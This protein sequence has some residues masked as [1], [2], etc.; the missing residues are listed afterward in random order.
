MMSKLKNLKKAKKKLTSWLNKNFKMYE[1]VIIGAGIA[2]CT[3]AIYAAR[4]KMNF[5]FIS[6]I[7][8][9]Q[10]FEA[11][12]VLNYPGIVKT[13]GIDFSNVLKRQLEF[14]NV[15]LTEGLEVKSIEKIKNGFKILTNKEEFTAK[16]VIIATGSH[17][18]RLNVK[19]EAEFLHKGLTYCAVCDGPFFSGMDIAIIGGGSSAL[20]AV[21]FTKNI[22]KKI[23][24]I[25][26]NK[27]FEAHEYLIEKTKALD[28]VEIISEADTIEVFGDK[29]VQGL[30]F[31]KN[32]EV[33]TLS[34][35]GIIVEIGRSP[36]TDFVKDFVEL[37]ERNHIKIDSQCRTSVPGVFAAG[38]CASGQEFQL[39]I[40]AGQ[41]CLA[42]LKAVRYLTR[43]REL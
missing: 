23:Y 37:D 42:L 28:N 26:K 8:G 15:E 40:A 6:K 20:E 36:N 33:N 19:G 30:K 1:T 31:V 5:L 3:A 11:C 24:V 17:P 25:N 43:L 10:F 9:G 18:K 4:K 13:T 22:A 35:R 2:G 38:D 12:E 39:V 27:E 32:G 7:F 16:T 29:F 14:N 21:D 34:V 41:G